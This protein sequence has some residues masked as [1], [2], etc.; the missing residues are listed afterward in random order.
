[1]EQLFDG[2]F[3]VLDPRAVLA[4]VLLCVELLQEAETRRSGRVPRSAVL[5]HA[6]TLLTA[7]RHLITNESCAAHF[8]HPGAATGAK[9]RAVRRKHNQ[10]ER[11]ALIVKRR[12]A[13]TVGL[14]ERNAAV[15]RAGMR[16]T[17]PRLIKIRLPAPWTAVRPCTNAIPNRT[18]LFVILFAVEESAIPSYLEEWIASPRSGS[19]GC[20][21]DSRPRV[22]IGYGKQ[23]GGG[24]CW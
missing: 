11:I 2:L 9:L 22:G 23:R 1:M 24:V 21:L 4:I 16:K 17:S 15:R 8:L 13:G 5:G 14:R 18:R 3:R 20:A 6:E 7:L 10:R 19:A 12:E